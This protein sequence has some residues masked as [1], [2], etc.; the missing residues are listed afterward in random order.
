MAAAR[1]GA[2]RLHHEGGPHKVFGTRIPK[3]LHRALK[4]HC[5]TVGTAVMDFVANGARREARALH[6][7]LGAASGDEGVSSSPASRPSH[8]GIV[9]AVVACCLKAARVE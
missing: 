8:A 7:H 1:G 9:G 4:S 3:P 6:R 5:V 2:V